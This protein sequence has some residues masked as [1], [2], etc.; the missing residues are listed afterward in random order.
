MA[1][2]AATVSS[3]ARG[4]ARAPVMVRLAAAF[5]LLVAVL[6]VAGPWLAPYDPAAQDLMLN[7]SGPSGAHWLGTDQLG[8]D[9]LSQVLAG[10]RA[11]LIGPLV[12]ALGTVVLGASLGILAGYRGGWIDALLNRLADLMY[13]LPSLLVIIVLV[14]VVGGGYWFAVLVLTVLSLPSEIRLCR[15]ATL[16]QARLPYI[17]AARTLGL[18]A[19]RIMARHLLPNIM[20]TVIATFLL[21]FVTALIGLSGLSY[22]GLGAPPGTPDWG[23]LLQSGQNLLADNPWISLAPGA[24]IALTATCFTLLGDWLYDRYSANGD[25]S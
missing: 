21:D 8:A 4:V 11:A 2:I 18:P 6:A 20:P 23:T 12:V 16:A 13:A 9:V 3:T 7:V 19:G 22:L 5:L 10:T 15:S 1:T 24:M 25:H 14:G 17:D